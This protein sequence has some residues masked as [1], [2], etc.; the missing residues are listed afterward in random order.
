MNNV[1]TF[2][3]VNGIW[4]LITIGCCLLSVIFQRQIKKIPLI[5]KLLDV[6]QRAIG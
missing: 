2:L 1:L 5:G 4:F 3:A 6:L